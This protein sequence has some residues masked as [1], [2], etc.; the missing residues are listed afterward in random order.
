MALTLRWRNISSHFKKKKKKAGFPFLWCLLNWTY[1][2][3]LCA[4]LLTRT[5]KHPY[6]LHAHT[7]HS[8]CTFDRNC[9][10]CSINVFS[11][12]KCQLKW[13][14]YRFEQNLLSGRLRA[15]LCDSAGERD[16]RPRSGRDLHVRGKQPRWSSGEWWR[17]VSPSQGMYR[18]QAQRWIL[19]FR[20]V[21][22]RLVPVRFV[23]FQLL[24][25]CPRSLSFCLIC[26]FKCTICI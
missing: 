3:L 18:F 22:F 10:N 16:H 6:N 24:S 20:S 1:I 25:F 19:N 13:R 8:I 2:F 21:P 23:S 7:T 26:H 17:F 4:L 11:S 9:V 14:S 5:H 15:G 12:W